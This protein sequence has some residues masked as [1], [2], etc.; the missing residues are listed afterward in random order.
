MRGP[1]PR[2]R[3]NPTT[4]RPASAIRRSIPAW[5]GKPRASDRRTACVAV[6]PRVGGETRFGGQCPKCMTGP[7]P[8]GRGNRQPHIQAHPG[9]RSIPAW[10]GKPRAKGK[11]VDAVPVHPRVGGETR[12][13]VDD[14]TG[15]G[16]HPRVGGETALSTVIDS[17]V[18][19][20]SPRGRGNLE[21]DHELVSLDG[22]IPAWAGKPHRPRDDQRQR[23]VHPR[24]GGETV[25]TSRR[26]NPQNGPSPRG[27]GNPPPPSPPPPDRRSIPAWAGKPC[28][29]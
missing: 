17:H 7:S 29:E 11:K 3:G 28:Q 21:V 6:H 20:P 25:P 23:S 1:S 13:E 27:R 9:G 10:A 15:Q 16:V 19:G 14:K 24:V 2:G 18:E 26:L 12:Y 22:S 5:A 8:R 4:N